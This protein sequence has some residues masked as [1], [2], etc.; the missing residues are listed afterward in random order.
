MHL[1]TLLVLAMLTPTSAFATSRV[2]Y[3][4]AT[5]DVLSSDLDG[6]NATLLT[7]LGGTVV[8]AA[9]DPTHGKVYLTS[10]TTSHSIVR[11]NLDGTDREVLLDN[12]INTNHIAVDPVGERIYWSDWGVD[13]IFS[14][15][16]DGTDVQ[17]VFSDPG[18]DAEG[19]AVDSV[20]GYLFV[21]NKSG[22]GIYQIALNGP[23]HDVIGSSSNLRGLAYNPYG[24]LL[25]YADADGSAAYVD[26]GTL[27]ETEIYAGLDFP[28]GIAMDS[29]P[30]AQVVYLANY[31]ASQLLLGAGDGAVAPFVLASGSITAVTV[32]A[33]NTG[34]IADLHAERIAAG[35]IT[36]TVTDATPNAQVGFAGGLSH[37]SFDIPSCPGVTATLERPVVLGSARADA[38][39]TATLTLTPP[40]RL[41]GTRVYVQA[42]DIG[43]C[44]TTPATVLHL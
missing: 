18:L 29:A 13:T 8:G 27:N 31:G 38:S 6:T 26:L 2:I 21:G 25:Y 11:M 17:N 3:G 37:G 12:A 42:L 9:V 28:L 33:N 43:G 7:N 16:L 1:Q 20:H 10:W 41:A 35:T 32:D 34:G 30:D 40:S 19:L 15:N 22:Q 44:L 14:A 24:N 4:T 36:L 23:V 39:G 5:G